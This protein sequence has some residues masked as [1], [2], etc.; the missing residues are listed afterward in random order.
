MEALNRSQ[1]LSLDDLN[2]IW[3]HEPSF[4]P[5]EI[6]PT[7]CDSKRSARCEE[8]ISDPAP[9]YSSAAS[10]AECTPSTALKEG[11]RSG[12]P[13]L[14]R[15][16]GRS[17]CRRAATS[18]SESPRPRGSNRVACH[19][20]TTEHYEPTDRAEEIRMHYALWMA[21]GACLVI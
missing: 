2:K 18:S 16:I 21:L 19:S 1:T 14:R 11:R 8:D 10:T 9:G 20:L 7:Y 3:D 15:R 17:F 12:S 4:D 13:T 6:L 5:N